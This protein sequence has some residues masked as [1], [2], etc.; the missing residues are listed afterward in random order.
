MTRDARAAFPKVWIVGT[1]SIVYALLV[2]V[3]FGPMNGIKSHSVLGPYL[4][5]V[6]PFTFIGLVIVEVLGLLWG[7]WVLIRHRVNLTG[8]NVVALMYGA[9]PFVAVGVFSICCLERIS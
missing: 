9:S 4:S 8:V 7:S 2:I 6:F 1:T 3:I 5:D